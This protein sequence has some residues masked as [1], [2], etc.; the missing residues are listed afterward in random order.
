MIKKNAKLVGN[1]RLQ[2]HFLSLIFLFLGFSYIMSAQETQISGTVTAADGGVPL[3]GVTVSEVNNSNNGVATNFDGEYQIT[4]SGPNTQLVF[5]YVGLESQ[6]IS[7]AGRSIIDIS[8]KEDLS[9]LDEV[10]VV[11]YG[12]QKKINLT[13]S[14]QTAEFNGPVNTPVTNAGQLMYGEFSGVQITQGNGL[15]GSDASDIVIRGVGTFGSTNPLIVIDGIQYENLQQFNNLAPSDIESISVLKDA[16]ASA[17]YGARGANGVIVVTTKGGR[18]GTMQVNVN[19][20]T[21]YQSATVVPEYLSAPDYARLRNERDINLDGEDTPLRYTDQDIQQMIDGSNP[22]QFANTKWS[23]VLLRQA[24]IQNHYIDFSGGSEKTTYKVSFNYL[25]QEAIVK[26]K[27]QNKRYT[28]GLNLKSDVKDWLTISNVFNSYWE[29]FKGPEGGADAITGEKGIINQFQRSSPTIPVFYSN[30][31]YGIVD[32]AYQR[33]NFSYG[34]DNGIRTGVLGDYSADRISISDR[35]GL[36]FNIAEGLTFETS[37]SLVLFFSNISNYNP[38]YVEEDYNGEIIS[39]KLTNSLF[40]SNNFNY[41]LL[42]E[43]IIRYAKSFNLHNFSVLGGFSVIY[44]RNDGFNGSLEGFPSDEIQEFNGGGVLNPSVNGG[45]SEET[46][47]SYFGRI[48]YNYNDKYLLEFNI[49]RDGSSK[50]GPDNR[51]GTFPSASAGWVL[52][53]E[54]FLNKTDWLSLLKIRGS[55]GI[56]GND[57]IGNYIYEQTYNSGLDYVLGNDQTVGAVALT[58]LANRSITWETIEQYDLGIDL[59]FFKNKFSFTADYFERESSDILYGNFPIPST[60]GVT[61]LAAQNAAS[62]INSGLEFSTSY[63]DNIGSLN[64]SINANISKFLNNEVTGLGENGAET[65][66]GNNIIRIGEPFRAYFGYKNIGI[67]QTQEEVDNAPVQFGNQNTGPG[68]LIYEDISGPD[69]TPDGIIDANDRQIIGNPYPEWVYNVNTRLNFAGIDLSILFQGV[70]N[71]DR[72]LNSN[73]QQ[74]MPDLRNNAL[75][76]WINRWTPENPSSELP[77]LGGQNNSATSDFYIQDAS[78][79]RLKNLELGYTI[80]NDVTDKFGVS[81]LRL[82]LAGQNLVTWTDFENF[83]PERARGG[84]SDQLTPLYK[85]YTIGINL[86]F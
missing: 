43:N 77:R 68:D 10:V 11:G 67:F 17:I 16:S 22:D 84:N 19:S 39:E 40:N 63:R 3:A 65:I 38:R 83:D 34:A 82:Y 44:D 13:G 49:R 71:I 69:G 56:S 23:D 52:S 20:Y 76:Y 8:M 9:Q 47:Q 54:S 73:G 46:L 59:A 86:Q 4:V 78:Y 2:R 7:V 24:P 30:G 29:V 25:N 15:P 66:G 12:K 26:G 48:N 35:L 61:N 79:L 75:S 36:Q 62:M 60:I 27:F 53:K 1:S 58:S 57:R 85:I 32:G 5:S 51:Y 6:T 28:L 18:A 31:N 72:Y 14:V 33:T 45:A 55:W 21:G 41:R 64:F 81:R 50:F 80:P 42:N 74:P 70:S 37:G